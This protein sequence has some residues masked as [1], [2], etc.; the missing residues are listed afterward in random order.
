LLRAAHF[1]KSHSIGLPRDNALSIVPILEPDRAGL[2]AQ[3]IGRGQR[4][5]S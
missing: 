1:I 5:A 4:A 2:G 3:S